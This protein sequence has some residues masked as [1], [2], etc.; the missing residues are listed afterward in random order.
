MHNATELAEINH[1][2]VVITNK[3]FTAICLNKRHENKEKLHILLFRITKTTKQKYCENEQN[4]TR[5]K[6]L[7][8]QKD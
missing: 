6:L 7:Q 8:K 1:C 3:M 2:I 4:T 5:H